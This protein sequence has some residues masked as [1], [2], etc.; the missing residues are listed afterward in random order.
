MHYLYGVEIV[1]NAAA[2]SESA[3]DQT[4]WFPTLSNAPTDLTEDACRKQI[5]DHILELD[6]FDDRNPRENRYY[7]CTTESLL[8]AFWWTFLRKHV[9]PNP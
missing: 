9:Y 3:P 2:G 7:I 4:P 8:W 5:R 6:D 1:D